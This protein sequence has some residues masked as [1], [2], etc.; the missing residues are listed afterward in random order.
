MKSLRNRTWQSLSCQQ[1]N[2]ATNLNS[3]SISQKSGTQNKLKK[4][5]NIICCCVAPLKRLSHPHC[6]VCVKAIE[7]TNCK[8]QKLNLLIILSKNKN[9]N[10]DKDNMHAYCKESHT[11]YCIWHTT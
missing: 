10:D 6:Q 4:S 2:I 7:K 5:Y 1:Q 3:N 8:L 9:L 11:H